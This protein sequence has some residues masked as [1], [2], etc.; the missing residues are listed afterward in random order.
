[1]AEEQNGLDQFPRE[2][3]TEPLSR[4]LSRDTSLFNRVEHRPA[5]SKP[6]RLGS[7][8]MT[9]SRG[10][11]LLRSISSPRSATVLRLKR[12]HHFATRSRNGLL[13][14]G[15]ALS[16]VLSSG[17]YA[18]VMRNSPAPVKPPR[19]LVLTNMA[20]F[21][22]P[23]T[24]DVSPSAAP[25]AI[26]EDVAIAEATSPARR[27]TSSLSALQE[28]PFAGVATPA[29]REPWPAPPPASAPTPVSTSV[30]PSPESSTRAADINAVE[31][32]LGRYRWAFNNR[33]A[34]AVESVWPSAN[35]KALRRAFGQME[36]QEFA[37][38]RCVTQFRIALAI[39]TCSGRATYV[40][41]IGTGTPRVESRR[42]T[43]TLEK[44]SRGWVVRQVQSG[45]AGLD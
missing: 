45:R 13:L 20:P 15:A 30:A 2:S 40:P 16:L 11:V 24:T 44:L 42:W 38:D 29:T 17:L 1:M 43:F 23:A 37:F 9:M 18:V 21:R 26:R 34:S 28:T 5:T 36:S 4:E 31:S 39:A 32:L 14:S 7:R 22:Y 8:S 10:L 12:L 33:D 25:A 3:W 35:V 19:D 27:R 41:R 6:G